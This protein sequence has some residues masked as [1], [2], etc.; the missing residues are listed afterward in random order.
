MID[1]FTLY[2]NVIGAKADKINRRMIPITGM[3]LFRSIYLPLTN[4]LTGIFYLK[5]IALTDVSVLEIDMKTTQIT[6]TS[7]ELGIYLVVHLHF[8][9][10]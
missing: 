4:I 2:P 8:H 3:L 9:Q 1:V 6:W 7:K 5:L 10:F